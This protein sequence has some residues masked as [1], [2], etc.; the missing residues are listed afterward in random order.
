MVERDG[1]P[2]RDAAYSGCHRIDV[3][4]DLIGRDIGGLFPKLLGSLGSQEAS[5]ADLQALD[6]R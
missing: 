6:A 1:R 3:R 4:Q 2:D 5:R